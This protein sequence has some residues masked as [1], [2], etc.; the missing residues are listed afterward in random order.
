MWTG[1]VL[2]RFLLVAV[3]GSLVFGIARSTITAVDGPP[4]QL[5]PPAVVPPMIVASAPL[6]LA[7]DTGWY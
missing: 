3:A 2:E 1:L 5:P 6:L 4:G 7:G